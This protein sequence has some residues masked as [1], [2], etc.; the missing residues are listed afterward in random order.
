MEGFFRKLA[1]PKSCHPGSLAEAVRDPGDWA[2]TVR[3]TWVADKR[4]ALSGMTTDLGFECGNYRPRPAFTA[5]ARS[6][7]SRTD[8]S[9]S[10]Q[11]SVTDW[12]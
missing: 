6:S 2:K 9:Q 3:F 12:P 1:T 10:T 5:A 8:V 11:A 4:C 7:S